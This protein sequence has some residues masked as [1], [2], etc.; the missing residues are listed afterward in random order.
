MIVIDRLFVPPQVT[1]MTI[2]V[3]SQ[4]YVDITGFYPISITFRVVFEGLVRT[5][6]QLSNS[7]LSYLL[8]VVIQQ[9]IDGYHTQL[10]F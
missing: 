8:R 2:T 10:P 5:L 1:G 7:F 4:P 3:Q 9:W 6:P